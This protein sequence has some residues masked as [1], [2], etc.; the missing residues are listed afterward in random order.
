MVETDPSASKDDVL[1]GT[2]NV[3]VVKI[4]GSSI[5]NKAKKESVNQD[6]LDWFA[7]IV[8]EA[9][10]DCYTAIDHTS[11]EKSASS[12]RRTAFIIIHGAGSFGHH[13]AKEYGLSGQTKAPSNSNSTVSLTQNKLRKKGL[14]ET[15]LSVQKLNHMV[16]ATLL[17]FGVNAVGI[18]PGFGVP[19]LEAHLHLQEEPSKA[20]ANVSLR[21]LEAGLIPV[22][23][24]DACLYGNDAAI[25]SGDTLVEVL[26]SLPWVSN[27]IFITDVD[28][29]FDEDPRKNPNARLLERIFVDPAT[30]V[31]QMDL[32]ASGSSHEHDVTGGLEV[33]SFV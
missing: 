33:S 17:R 5:T 13:S 20:L 16:V 8:S 10:G 29:V 3:V 27:T 19:G 22:L 23:H 31:I 30:G 4:G 18:S 11:R 7:K 6:A 25:L 21:T 15:R 24:G 12:P 1:G 32:N 14:S 26:G 9:V 28:G 2:V